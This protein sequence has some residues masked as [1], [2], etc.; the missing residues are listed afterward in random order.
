[1]AQFEKD[2]SCLR[3]LFGIYE[4]FGKTWALNEQTYMLIWESYVRYF[5]ITLATAATDPSVPTPDHLR[6][7]LLSCFVSNDIYATEAFPRLIDMLDTNQDLSANTKR[8]VFH[9]LV[10]CVSQ[11]DFATV[12]QFAP[13]VWESIKFEIWNGE[14]DDFVSG[15]LTVINA[16]VQKLSSN[17]HDWDDELNSSARFL[18]ETLK[19]C[20]EKI[21]DSKQR[22]ML[23]TGRIIYAIGSSSPWAFSW[24]IKKILPSL[25]TF[26]DDL[27]V[28]SEKA[29]MLGVFNRILQARID[30]AEEVTSTLANQESTQ[31][32]RDYSSESKKKLQNVLRPFKDRLV[33][34]YWSA[35][36][37]PKEQPAFR[38][39]TVKGLASLMAFDEFLGD[40]EKGTIIESLNKI[41]LDKN[42]LSDVLVEST[43]ALSQISIADPGRFRDITLANFTSELPSSINDEANKDLAIHI[44]DA[45]LQISCTRIC[46]TDWQEDPN[47]RFAVFN[48]FQK[49]LLKFV[50]DLGFDQL[51][52]ISLAL[53]AVLRGLSLFDAALDQ[54][55]SSSSL[56]AHSATHPYSFV[57][58]E[59][60]AKFVKHHKLENE[61][62]VGLGFT[63]PQDQTELQ[64]ALSLLGD[65]LTLATRSNQTIPS[66]SFL[67][68]DT[69][70]SSGVWSL[71]C[72]ISEP[73]STGA[74]INQFD[75]RKGPSDK[76]LVLVLSKSLVAG[77]RREDKDK[78][79][80]D[81]GAITISMIQNVLAGDENSTP[82]TRIAALQFLQLLVNKFG[83]SGAASGKKDLTVAQ[84]LEEIVKETDTS[85][86]DILAERILQ[87]LTYYTTAALARC[88]PS[89]RAFLNLMV[90]KI[91]E[92]KL[93]RKVAQSFRMLLHQSDV[94][95]KENFAI[96]R[97]LRQGRLYS[98]VVTDLIALWRSTTEPGVK[99][100]YLVALT[101][102]LSSMDPDVYLDN[103]ETILPLLLEG[104]NIP[105]DDWTK[106]AC[107]TCIR[108]LI[109]LRPQVVASHLDSVINRMT[110]RTRNTYFSP[111]DSNAACR[112]AAVDILA[113]LTKHVDINAL[114]KRK[115]KV[116]V[117]LDGAVDDV[118]NVVRERAQRCKLAWFNLIPPSA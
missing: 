53:G 63:I 114:L 1:M 37:Q 109:P 50:R 82:F 41:V 3:V 54:E 42:E 20:K 19:E 4:E 73:E 44:L 116:M 108:K 12:L 104:T 35:T 55:A 34:V 49:Q 70:G 61:S 86:N 117:E 10:A 80:F 78:L 106:L 6:A 45:L 9:T 76:C 5:P 95:R 89:D 15:S 39:Q 17:F 102:I 101:A 94:L 57:V 22:Y 110:D 68:G 112:A 75:T 16:L 27:S 84:Y 52:Y 43:T 85:D 29:A 25:L 60:L 100:S 103:V 93:G 7:L 21:L 28:T 62:Y 98:H 87:V 26:W 107:I 14:N 69:S 48:I 23:A 47:P 72:N 92:P 56:T 30:V 33:E 99:N 79:G 66:N 11:Y 71:F 59:L 90:A 38:I 88:D 115:S 2:P 118:S 40:M 67:N 13:K 74:Y 111:S 105:N 36:T 31:E 8:D 91:A 96:I 51:A 58:E 83:A 97:P 81:V 32:V 18:I 77:F 24:V 113:L 64:H 65:I 46:N